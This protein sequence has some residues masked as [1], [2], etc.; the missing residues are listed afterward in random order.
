MRRN[1]AETGGG[2]EKETKVQKHKQWY[3]RQAIIVDNGVCVCVWERESVCV[4]MSVWVCE[5]VSV[6]VCADMRNKGN[7]TD[8]L[9]IGWFLLVSDR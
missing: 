8:R 4:C 9:V 7:I 2:G 5:C 1:L 3:S 6:S